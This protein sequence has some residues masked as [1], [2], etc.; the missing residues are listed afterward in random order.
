MPPSKFA[1]TYLKNADDLVRG[2]AELPLAAIDDATEEGRALL[3]SAKHILK[4]LGKEGQ[5]VLVAD[6]F[7][8]PA[9]IFAQSRF[10][11]DG[12][13][14]ELSTDDEFLRSV[15]RDVMDSFGSDLDRSGKQGLSE[16]KVVA[17]FTELQA[18]ADW[19]AAA[20]TTAGVLVLERDK[21]AQAS[22]A[23]AAVRG[24]IDD[25]FARC[26]L[27]AF[28]PRTLPLLNR[29]EE[30]YAQVVA[31]DL[32]PTLKELVGFPLAQIAPGR[33]LN[34]R[35]PLNPAHA[36]SIRTL[37]E[38]A[39][40][41]LLGP[42]DHLTEEDW[43]TLQQRVAP[44]DA[45]YATKKGDRIEKLTEPRILEML[46]S[47]AR[48]DLL[49]LL[50]QDKAL[51]KEAT[52]IDNVERLFRYHRDL[53]LVCTN[54]VNF[55]DFYSGGEPA[56]FQCGTLYIDQRACQLCLRVQDAAKHAAMAGLAG[57]CLVYADCT[58]LGADKM[59]IVAA[60]TNGDSDNLIVG[61]N[62]LFFDRLGR[63]WDA[64]IT[65]IVDNPISLRQA[66]W[67]PYK[68]LVR[69]IEEQ[70]AK[71]AAA[72]DAKS[73][74]TLSSAASTAANADTAALPQAP[75]QG[76]AEAKKIDVG[77]V[78]ALG[79]AVGALGAF[80]TAMVGYATGILQMG[81]LATIGAFIGVLLLISLPS[82]VLAYITLRKRN[83]GPILDA[84]GWAINA[85]AKVNVAFGATLTTLA[86]LP[87]GCRR[88]SRD[89]YMDRGLPWKRVL[90]AVILVT[91]AYRWYQGAFDHYVP[92]DFQ[93]TTVLGT[94]A[95]EK[96]L[97][98]TPPATH[99]KK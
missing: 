12:V 31:G 15:M 89:R 75:Q 52:S 23:L 9:K 76:T 85:N 91:V 47:T 65:K 3:S 84:S 41:P 99:E 80:L 74:T 51:E 42:R 93:S 28:D 32:T 39:V 20:P 62:G 81:M 54:F 33:S 22:A 40:V 16:E 24:K 5:S 88:D 13:I 69:M 60:V 37:Q 98:A 61:R 58:R 46:K 78:A 19:K 25:F 36:A 97:P 30:E 82:V 8:D 26:R 45:W 18:Y 90:A 71:R 35:G 86:K 6:D 77:A 57:A 94:F 1:G 96:P 48:E 79:V 10:N 11:G 59:S 4:N 49:Q 70:V 38:H 66:F 44:Y 21:M 53:Y 29:K 50:A 7:A 43:M 27:A 72:A 63:D 83:L 67:A 68:K 2:K 73:T 55:R 17:F 56:V 92:E 34:L 14:T 95:P 64:T 87:A